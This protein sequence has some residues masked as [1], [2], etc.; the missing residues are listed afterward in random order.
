MNARRPYRSPAREAQ[1]RATR[2]RILAATR[3][4]FLERGYAAT[5]MRQ[6]AHEGAVALPTLTGLFPSKRALLDE[7]LRS[8]RG[9]G[10]DASPHADAVEE[11][12]RAPDPG[13]LIA[14]VAA[15]DRGAN[16]EAFELLEILRTAAVVEPEM[17]ARRRAGADDRRRDRA[18]IAR[19]L[20]RRGALPP[21]ISVRQATDVLWFYGS[22][23]T[24]R[25]LVADAGWTPQRFER[26]VRDALT[27]ALVDEAGA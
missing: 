9:D 15:L 7:V 14:R 22:A 1:A 25:L 13:E 19:E 24:Y 12:L 8:L 6:I 4:L 2:A 27:A 20:A 3:R 21:E 26:F 18:R 17:E 23:D 5:T 11:I 10:D 16:E